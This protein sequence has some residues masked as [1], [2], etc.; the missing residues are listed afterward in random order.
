MELR[1]NGHKDARKQISFLKMLYKDEPNYRY[2]L[3]PI[4]K[5]ILYKKSDFARNSTIWTCIVTEK[6]AIKASAVFIYTKNFNDCMQIAFFEA[7]PNSHSAVTLLIK[8][9]K[10]LAVS[11]GLQRITIGLNGHLNNGFG[12]LYEGFSDELCFGCNWNPAYYRDYFESFHFKKTMLNVLGGKASDMNFEPYANALARIQRTYH[13]RKAS[14]HN[15]KE[16]IKLYTDLSNQCFSEH[17]F[18]APRSYEEIYGL[19]KMFRYLITE[20]NLLFVEKENKTVGYLLWY[21]DFNQITKP[22][23]TV[24]VFTILKNKLLPRKISRLK[25]AEIGILPQYRRTGAIF[26]LFHQLK[27][28]AGDQYSEFETSRVLE[29]NKDSMSLADYFPTEIK[30][31]YVIYEGT[32]L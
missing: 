16:E 30:R 15:L 1:L 4:L 21:P 12:L 2:T 10:E 31:R 32:V 11:L 8:K 5:S 24:G 22:D 19:F 25:I 6:D 3:I 14:F 18:F 26:E 20:N 9:A 7:L 28:I 13:V 29:Y 23:R 27:M 17:D